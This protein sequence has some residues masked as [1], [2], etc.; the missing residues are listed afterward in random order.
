MAE[1]GTE[2]IKRLLQRQLIVQLGCLGVTQADIGKI[3]GIDIRTVNS[4]MK[5]V[6]KALRKKNK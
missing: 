3:V 6:S 1:T 4:V 2:V 5:P